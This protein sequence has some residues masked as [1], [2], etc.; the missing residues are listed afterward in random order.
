MPSGPFVGIRVL[1][2][3]QFEAGPC[4]TALMSDMGAEVIKIE[5]PGVGDPG[6]Y[7]NKR[8]NGYSLYFNTH[9]R[10]KRSVTL[11]VRTPEGREIIHKLIKSADVM[12]NN[13]Q[14][15]QMERMGLGYDQV[16]AINPRII[17]ASSSA[18]GPRG[19]RAS[20]AGFASTGLAESGLTWA[21]WPDGKPITAMGAAL[22]GDQVPGV[23]LAFA[24]SSALVARERTGVGQ[25]VDTSQ[26]G[27]LVR[28][29]NAAINTAMY[30]SSPALPPGLASPL[31]AGSFVCGDGKY[32]SMG[33]LS[34]DKW[35]S[36]C[37]ALEW[38]DWQEDPGYTTQQARA[39]KVDS[40]R[41][42]LAET[43][44]KRPASEWV[45]R[46]DQYDMPSAVVQS[47]AD[48]GNDPQ[49]LANGYITE[50]DDPRWGKQRV[51]GLA[52]E[53]EKT[54][55]EVQG[56]APDL[57]EHTDQYLSQIGYSASQ[58]ANLRTKKVV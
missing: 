57:G 55:G 38:N 52:I 24:I 10:G 32:L 22:G 28:M 29:A 31:I 42:R 33:M 48:V 19:P 4:A 49:V 50:V 20:A 2:F 56:L 26:L 17:Y 27:A 39:D 54:P 8:E 41:R 7:L 25:R 9:S 16:S 6:R 47:F 44:L 35:V 21:S 14:V 15:G 43:F 12:V 53:M 13:R 45:K 30:T 23:Y 1:D 5:R 36:L 3:T 11:D 51:V 37:G 58:I 34:V 40:I 18:Y 46:F